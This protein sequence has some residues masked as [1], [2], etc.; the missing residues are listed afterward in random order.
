[1]PLRAVSVGVE[2][3]VVNNK[4][5]A[6]TPKTIASPKHPSARSASRSAVSAC[7]VVGAVFKLRFSLSARKAENVPPPPAMTPSTPVTIAPVYDRGAAV[8][9]FGGAPLGGGADGVMGAGGEDWI[10][11]EDWTDG[12][13]ALGRAEGTEGVGDGALEGA[14]AV[15][16]PE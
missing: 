15:T 14:G 9:D 3:L 4:T 6:V 16:E 2:S 1:L 8:V 5:A 7:S 13:P 10:A 11:G 12:A